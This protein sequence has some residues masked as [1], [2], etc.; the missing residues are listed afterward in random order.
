MS[1]W[2][3]AS[4]ES[5]TLLG[6]VCR[7]RG[8]PKARLLSVEASSDIHPIPRSKQSWKDLAQFMERAK[9]DLHVDRPEDWKR[10]TKS[11]IRKRGGDPILRYHGNSIVA[12]L[13]AAYPQHDW[14]FMQHLHTTK[15][16]QNLRQ[17]LERFFPDVQSNYRHDQLLH[18]ESGSKMEL[19]FWIPSK[20]LAIE[21]QGEHHYKPRI[22]SKDLQTKREETKRKERRADRPGSR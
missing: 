19:D 15:P 1:L 2:K 21:Y 3:I 20:Q 8:D 14:S 13:R 10:I 22:L 11:Y 4:G 7:C 18:P 16:E 5:K 17:I 6:Y 12:M 9:R